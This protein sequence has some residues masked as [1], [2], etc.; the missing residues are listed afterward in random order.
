MDYM[1]CRACVCGNFA[2]V[3]PTTRS[4]TAQAEPSS[5]L[6]ALKFG[7]TKRW[8]ISKHDV[9]GAF[10]N[11]KI[12]DGKLVIVTPPKQWVDWGIVP[13]GETWTLEKAVYGLRESP[14][15]WSEERDRQLLRVEWTVGKENYYLQ[16][17]AADSQLWTLKSIDPSRKNEILGIL[18]VY[19]D[20]FLL[21]ADLGP[22]RDGLLEGLGKIWK[23]DKEQTLN[24]EQSLT[25]LGIEMQLRPNQDVFLH[26]TKFVKGLLDKYSLQTS[27]GNKT[28][29][30]DKL[31]LVEEVPEK[32]VLR[33]LQAFSGELNWLATRTRPDIGYYTSLLASACS[34]HA[35]W[36]QEFALK[37]LRYLNYSQ[38]EGILITVEGD[39]DD[40]IAWTDAGYAGEDTKS[41]SGLVISWGGSIIVWR[42]SRQTVATLSTAEAELN[43]A[44]LGWQIVEGLRYLLA[45]FGIDVPTIKVLIDNKAALTI[46]MC[47][48]AWRTRYFAV[49]GHRLHQE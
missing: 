12:P 21:Q 25:F 7:R 40:L 8:A 42:S 17:C 13:P 36:S 39:L 3:D 31:P 26:Q 23:L 38:D 41:Q 35:T 10:L 47:G 29:Q 2:D 27:K 11:A 14:R 9:K 6:S 4:W 30:I 45:D 49:R 18:V 15:L 37:I 46:A 33:K 19:V 32:I 44:T 5:L 1:K 34:K 22:I 28:V 16:R 48:A 24:V 20:D 43:A